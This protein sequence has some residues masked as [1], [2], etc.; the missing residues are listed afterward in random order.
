MHVMSAVVQSCPVAAKTPCHHMTQTCW[1][2]MSLAAGLACNPVDL[3]TADVDAVA[4]VS[5]SLAAAAVH[6]LSNLDT[7]HHLSSCKS[8][9]D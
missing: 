5:A 3:N 4:C 1:V 7:P 2:P 6:L 9:Q 8:N